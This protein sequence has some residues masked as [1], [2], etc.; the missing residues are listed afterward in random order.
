MALECMAP[1]HHIP[2][3]CFA[4]L[5]VICASATDQHTHGTVPVL[6]ITSHKQQDLKQHALDDTAHICGGKW[7]G[8][9]GVFSRIP[10]F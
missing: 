3:F 10:I 5:V 6:S 4:Q 8:L 2:Y 1:W 7:L 9:L